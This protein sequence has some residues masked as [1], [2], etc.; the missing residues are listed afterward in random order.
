MISFVKNTLLLSLA[1][2]LFTPPAFALNVNEVTNPR[3]QNKWVSDL[4]GVIN[5]ID[6]AQINRR[7]DYLEK[8]TGVEITVDPSTD[9]RCCNSKRFFDP[10]F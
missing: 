1:L 4:A 10:T 6:E 9:F 8:Q 2:L 7:I 5:D 3:E